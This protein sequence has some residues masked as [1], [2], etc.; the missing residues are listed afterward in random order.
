[1]RMHAMEGE[2]DGM[3]LGSWPVAMG[4]KPGHQPQAWPALWVQTLPGKINIFS[5]HQ[6]RV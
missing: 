5:G 1:M 6:W 4:C 3:T 2:L